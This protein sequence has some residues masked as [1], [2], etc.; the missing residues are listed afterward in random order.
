MRKVLLVICLLLSGVGMQ[1]QDFVSRFLEVHQP[2]SNLTCITISPKMMKKIVNV[3][4][5]RNEKLIDVIA[6]LN[7]MQMLTAQ[8]DGE[9]YYNAAIELLDKNNKRFETFTVDTLHHAKSRVAMCKKDRKS[10]V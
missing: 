8:V 6:D 5:G 9:G 2:D 7:S 3:D 4:I 10:V 1:A